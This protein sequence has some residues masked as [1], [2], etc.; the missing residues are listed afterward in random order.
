MTLPGGVIFKDLFLDALWAVLYFPLWWYGRGLKDTAI[1]CW[2]KIVSGWRA[3]AISIFLVNFFKPMY[4]QS[5]FLSRVLSVITHLL[6][7]LG[8]LALFFCWALFWLLILILWIIAPLYA[9]WE[10]LV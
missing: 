8:R 7:I 6:Q 10:A 5:D 3:L 9:L 1:F 2:R 4:G